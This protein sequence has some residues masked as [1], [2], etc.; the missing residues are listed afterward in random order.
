MS[1]EWHRIIPGRNFVTGYLSPWGPQDP[2]SFPSGHVTPIFAIQLDRQFTL[3]DVMLVFP[4]HCGFVDLGVSMPSSFEGISLNLYNATPDDSFGQACTFQSLTSKVS[5]QDARYNAGRYIFKIGVHDSLR[6]VGRLRNDVYGG[7]VYDLT[8]LYM[9]ESDG[10][11]N[12]G[13][14]FFAS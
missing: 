8:G 10:W 5:S 14:S 3:S 4:A 6:T 9:T 13:V 7:A 12:I 11:C 1:S 2:L